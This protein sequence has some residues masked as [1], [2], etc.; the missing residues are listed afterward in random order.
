[1]I[2][3][4]MQHPLPNLLAV[5]VLLA[6]IFSW[7]VSIILALKDAPILIGKGWYT[8]IMLAFSLLGI[9]AI[10]DL[11]QA[12]GIAFVFAVIASL[13]IIIN[14]AILCMQL[15]GRTSHSLV[16]DWSKWAIPILVLGGL[17]VAGYFVFLEFTGEQVVCGPNVEGCKAVQNSKY[18]I[19]FGIIPMGIFGFAGYVAILSGWFLW[20]YGPASL[21]KLGSLS[22]WGFCVF[23]VLFS[24]YLTFLEPFV[25][26]ATCMWCITSAVLMI[27]LLL[28]STPAAQQALAIQAEQEDEFLPNRA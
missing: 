15:V 11:L 4:F 21:R 13:A 10:L 28:V 7:F 18:A 16:K 6:L 12:H 27:E 14:I 5:I 1:M 8:K 9:P 26:G 20:Q 22:M 23:G 3:K 2:E 25:I 24:I 19:L 17:A